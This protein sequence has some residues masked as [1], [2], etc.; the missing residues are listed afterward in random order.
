MRLVFANG[1]STEKENINTAT[2][3]L[4]SF[5]NSC[6]VPTIESSLPTNSEAIMGPAKLTA[7]SIFNENMGANTPGMN[8]PIAMTLKRN[9]M[10]FLSNLLTLILS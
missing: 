2:N 3:I 1:I 7:N 9:P 5:N 6:T 4:S 10:C 8:S